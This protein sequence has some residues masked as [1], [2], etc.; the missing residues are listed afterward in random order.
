MV[1]RPSE[2]QLC[3]RET[4]RHASHTQKQSTLACNQST[5]T[6][7]CAQG[8]LQTNMCA[9]CVTSI[10][11]Y[12][13]AR[14]VQHSGLFLFCFFSPFK[15][16]AAISL[17]WVAGLAQTFPSFHVS[18]PFLPDFPCFQVP[19]GSIFPPQLRS[20]SR[21]LPSIF[22]STTVWMLS[23]SS[24]L[25]TCPSHSISFIRR[26]KR[27]TPLPIAPFSSHHLG[28]FLCR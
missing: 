21:A 13:P 2:V 16:F 7:R 22:T 18:G 4:S 25:L 23:V 9:N 10:G 19:P 24:L 15:P 5:E 14:W 17:F 20:S 11:L 3:C 27:L 6:I 8:K 1:D 26:S 28:L 12:L